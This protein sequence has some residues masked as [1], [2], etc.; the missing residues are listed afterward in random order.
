MIG[1]KGYDRRLYVSYPN[2]GNTDETNR[3]ALGDGVS[4]FFKEK[5]FF[6]YPAKKV[7]VNDITNDTDP[8]PLDAYFMDDDIQEIVETAVG[9]E[10]LTTDF[11]AN[12]PQMASVIYGGNFPSSWARHKLGFPRANHN[13]DI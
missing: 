6:Q 2:D 1:E 13:I 9:R 10:F 5:K 8:I 11:C 4:A 3:K 7:V 12:F